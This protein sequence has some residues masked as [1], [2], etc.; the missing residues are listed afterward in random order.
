MSGAN[1]VKKMAKTKPLERKVPTGS[2]R[3][4]SY[5]VNRWNGEGFV[6]TE[7]P[8]KIKPREPTSDRDMY[9]LE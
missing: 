1:E 7:Y 4:L 8:L 9:K 6:T 2:T 5:T 3:Q